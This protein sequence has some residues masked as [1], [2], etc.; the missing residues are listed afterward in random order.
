MNK[1]VVFG[2]GLSGNATVKFLLKQGYTVFAADD[3]SASLFNLKQE[4]VNSSEF[5]GKLIIIDDYSRID[6][7]GVD[8]LILSPGIPLHYPVPHPIVSL[9]KGNQCR[10]ICD[11]ELLFDYHP[12]A[13]FLGITG[14]N[15]KSTTTALVGHILTE[16]N[17]KNAVGGNIGKPAL[18]MPD[19]QE[20]EFYVLEMSSYQLDLIDRTRFNIAALLNITPDHLDRHNDMA[21]YIAAKKRIF[22][23]QQ[24]DDYAVI[25]IDN[26]NSRK[27]YQDLSDDQNYRGNLIA[28]STKEVLPHGVSITDGFIINNIEGLATKILL[29]NLLYLKGEHNLQNVVVAFTVACLAGASQEQIVAAIKSFKGLKHR[30]QLIRT[31]GSINFINDSKA[32]NSDSTENALKAY[33]NI[34]LIL[35]GRP[36]DGGIISL[37]PYFKKITKAYLIGEASV[38]FAKVLAKNEVDFEE[39]GYLENAF[40]KAY[41]D[42]ARDQGGNLKE[43]NIILSPACASF[44]QWKNF[45][46]RGDYFCQLVMKL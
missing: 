1:Y 43:K 39:C 20:Q 12:K 34:Y 5:R 4:V 42:A 13:Y 40:N 9:A 19:L 14:T 23:N 7:Q 6:W 41:Q 2:L 38:D 28:V 37:V 22:L 8:A 11:I 31:I 30:L 21:G 29:S 18:L 36:K 33:N 26:E 17:K 46:V 44:D 3:N 25:C 35:G 32:T 24:K 10:I 15:G 27:V 16:L 45:E